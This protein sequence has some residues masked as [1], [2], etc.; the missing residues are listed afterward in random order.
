M[1]SYLSLFLSVCLCLLAVSIGGYVFCIEF[2]YV[3]IGLFDGS[4][5]FFV[6]CIVTSVLFP[7][8]LVFN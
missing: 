1:I 4:S 7:L 2:A 8:S 5:I 6:P 3:G